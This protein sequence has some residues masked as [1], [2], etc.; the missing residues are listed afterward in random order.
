MIAEAASP[1]PPVPPTVA[2]NGRCD[3]A[4]VPPTA[5]LSGRCD[6][7]T[8][9]PHLPT[10]SP[11]ARHILTRFFALQQ[12]PLALA[13]DLGKDLLDILTLLADPSLVAWINHFQTLI[14]ARRRELALQTLEALCKSAQDPVEQRRTAARLLSATRRVVEAQP[15][16]RARTDQPLIKPNPARSAADTLSTMLHVIAEKSQSSEQSRRTLDAHC[17]FNANVLGVTIESDSEDA[18]PQL[19]NDPALAPLQVID[20]GVEIALSKPTI[21]SASLFEQAATL[22]NRHQSRLLTFT[23]RPSETGWQIT[24]IQAPP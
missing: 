18:L 24:R 4:P 12:D 2:L 8:T 9:S 10:L 13:T 6:P 17:A 21:N 1:V 5:A 3:P 19:E 22:S 15:P 20:A 14:T 7:P 16:S 23:F 11:Q